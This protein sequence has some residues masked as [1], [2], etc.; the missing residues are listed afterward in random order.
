LTWGGH[1]RRDLMFVGGLDGKLRVWTK[2]QSP[3]RR[4]FTLAC[5]A[6][7]PTQCRLVSDGVRM[8]VST[9][10]ADPVYCGGRPGKG[11]L[12]LFDLRKLGDNEQSN[13]ALVTSY[14]DPGDENE[15]AGVIDM[16]VSEDGGE[17]LALCLVDNVVRAYDLQS[18]SYLQPKFDFD[19]VS[20]HDAWA[21]GGAT[22]VRAC[23]IA[24][25]GRYVMTGTTSPSLDVWRRT[26]VDAPYGHKSFARPE[27]PPAM[28][29]RARCVPPGQHHADTALALQTGSAL[30]QVQ[31]SLEL[32]RQRAAARAPLALPN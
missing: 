13:S 26:E 19:V 20:E 16:T 25:V 8:V 27:P 29:L 15:Q 7:Q 18:N 11:G 1:Q 6:S 9:T 22:T 2:G 12:M 17:V 24:A 30:E 4:E 5:N 23:A 3:L 31:V 10:P 21:Q 32:D 28:V 14:E